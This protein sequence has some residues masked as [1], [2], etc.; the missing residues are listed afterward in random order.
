MKK[1]T[2][3]IFLLFG[4]KLLAQTTFSVSPLVNHK[5][6]FCSFTG[7]HVTK[8][9]TENNPTLVPNPYFSFDA[10]RISN[11]P[12]I[13]IGIRGELGFQN[14]KYLLN[15]EFASDA[16]GTMSKTIHFA[17]TNHYPLPAPSYKTYGQGIGYVQGG[18]V[19]NRL[20]LQ[21]G[22]RLTNENRPYKIYLLTDFSIIYGKANQ[23][24][25]VFEADSTYISTYFHNDAKNIY[26][27]N[28]F[29]Y[30]GKTSVLFGIGLKG[31]IGFKTKKKEHYLFSLEAFM[32]QGTRFIMFSSHEQI[33]EDNNK[34]I[35]F[36]N[37]LGTR[38]SGIYFQI[39]RKFQ[40]Y[41]WRPNKKTKLEHE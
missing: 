24:T 19:Y 23:S 20:S 21:Y 4:S 26:S 25:W 15:V 2:F 32:R 9:L 12:A 38:G 40:L 34:Q 27:E 5:L 3:Y 16:S 29:Y 31:D 6:H 33:I 1:T 22:Y 8:H 36:I 14:S 7:T 30:Y 37:G 10:K 35:G 39:S 28:N 11:R 41:P 17:T 18:F 13:D